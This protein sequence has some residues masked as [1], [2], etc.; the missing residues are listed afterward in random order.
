MVDEEDQRRVA[1]ETALGAISRLISSVRLASKSN[2][3]PAYVQLAARAAR[4]CYEVETKCRKKAFR[5]RLLGFLESNIPPWV[6]KRLPKPT[7]RARKILRSLTPQIPS[8]EEKTLHQGY[9]LTSIVFSVM[10]LEATINLLFLDACH[11]SEKLEEHFGPAAVEELRETWI[12]AEENKRF[13]PT[14]AKFQDAA[15]IARKNPP[16]ESQHWE[17]VK[18]LIKI[19]NGLT[20]YKAEFRRAG[21]PDTPD[22]ELDELDRTVKSIGIGT[23]PLTGEGN[24][25]FPDK[26]LGHECA[27]WGLQSAVGF[28][29]DFYGAM[30]IPLEGWLEQLKSVSTH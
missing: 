19:R 26:C 6:I 7:K 25:W 14:R 18:D 27:E 17:A 9:A 5:E 16:D 28:V 13:W 11:E 10:F 4:R 3:V 12:Q 23:H 24:P 15:R 8:D 21:A 29:K 22:D 1:A 2:L 30:G 20:H